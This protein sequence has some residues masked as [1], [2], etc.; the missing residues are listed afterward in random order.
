M[1]PQ[2][3]TKRFFKRIEGFFVSCK[4]H[5]I[6]HHLLSGCG[7]EVIPEYMNSSLEDCG[8]IEETSPVWIC[9]W[10]G[11]ESMPDIVK[12]CYRSVLMHA[13]RHPVRLITE[14]N[15]RDYVTIPTFI[16][17]KQQKREI[18]FLPIIIYPRADGPVSF[19]H[20]E[21]EIHCLLLL[22]ICIS[23]IGSLIKG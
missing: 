22:Q 11:E 23:L 6:L 17:E 2:S 16:L 20:V 8:Q 7:K 13:D 21:R 18:I 9:W 10:Q 1:K 14:H 15:Y 3:R 12:A 4:Q 19:W 5:F